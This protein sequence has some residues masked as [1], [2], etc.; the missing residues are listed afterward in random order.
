M[1][2]RNDH[3]FNA[4]FIKMVMDSGY[5]TDNQEFIGEL[6]T[7]LYDYMA[8]K[9]SLDKRELSGYIVEVTKLVGEAH[10]QTLSIDEM[11]DWILWYKGQGYST[12]KP[13]DLPDYL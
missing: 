7:T 5:K 9:T 6:I 3:Y 8:E 13:P 12:P 11:V 2:E 1:E 4:E 10:V